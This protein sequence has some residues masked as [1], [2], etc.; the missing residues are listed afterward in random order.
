MTTAEHRT[1]IQ[2]PAAPKATGPYSQAI[3]ANGMVFCSGQV[4]VDPTTNQL[5]EGDV[6]TQTRRALLN[7]DAVLK[8]AGS[9]LQHVVKVN[10]FLAHF[11]DWAA[12]NEVYSEFFS[13]P[14]PARSAIEAGALPRNVLVE[15]ECTALIPRFIETLS[16]INPRESESSFDLDQDRDF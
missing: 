10:I 15:V 8:A 2:T 5:I 7:L 3:V 13:D 9:G 12:M 6:R 4:A 16:S 1:R 14:L 11:S